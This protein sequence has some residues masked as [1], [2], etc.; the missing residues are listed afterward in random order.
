M[1][2]PHLTRIL[3]VAAV[4][5][6]LTAAC[7]GGDPEPTA[8]VTATTGP[9]ITSAAPTPTSAE[10][11]E[12]TAPATSVPPA[13]DEDIPAPPP[14]PADTAADTNAASADASLSPVDMR[15]GVHDG[16]DRLVIDLDGTGQPGWESRYVS[17][18]QADGSGESVDL[19]GSAY[20]Q[21][22]IKGVIYPTEAGATEY[23]GAR[24]FQPASAGVIEEVVYGDVF[25][26]QAEVYIGVSS[27][28]P[29]RVFLLEDPTRM[30]IDIYHP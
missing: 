12:S 22:T 11:T 26:G 25:E 14:F 6:L 29:F 5:A 13:D 17:D 27:K 3:A 21:T 16:F 2:R 8:T 30:V 24:R 23:G 10:P 9:A 28:Q 7:G 19:D 4:G 15:F 1:R 20:L 18:P